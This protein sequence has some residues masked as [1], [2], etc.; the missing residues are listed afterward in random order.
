MKQTCLCEYLR[1]TCNHPD[2]FLHIPASIRRRIYLYAGL[3]T[4]TYIAYP[5]IGSVEGGDDCTIPHEDYVVTYNLTHVCQQIR[6]EVEAIL[7]NRNTCVYFDHNVDDGLDYLSQI[8][9]YTCSMLRNVYVHLYVHPDRNGRYQREPSPLE[10]KRI[11]M[12]QLATTNILSH[13]SP[14]RLRLH[15]ICDTGYSKKTDAVLQPLCNFPGV[16][17]ELELRLHKQE[18]ENKRLTTLARETA[19]QA[20]G[21]N[22][23]APSGIFRFFDL[24]EEIRRNIFAYTNLVAPYRKVHWEPESGFRAEFIFC[25]CD[26]SVCLEADLHDGRRFLSC[27]ADSDITG[28]FCMRYRSS[29]SSRCNHGSSPLSL[30]LVSR[31]MYEEAIAFFYASNRIIIQPDEQSENAIFAGADAEPPSHQ[32]GAAEQTDAATPYDPD[33]AEF[34][35][36]KYMRHD[37]TKLF[38][39]R[40]GSK[41]LRLV[42]NLEIVFPRIGP[43]SSLSDADPAYSEWCMA[44]DYLACLAAHADVPRLTLIV[45]IWTTPAGRVDWPLERTA[46]MVE[47]QAPRLL[48]PLRALSQ[49]ERLFVHLEWP[50]HWSPP[51]LLHDIKTSKVPKKESPGCGIGLHYIPR[52]EEVVAEKEVRLEKMVMDAEYDSYSMGKGDELPSQWVRDQWGM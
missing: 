50:K 47:A 4:G 38:L 2:T 18:H 31:P 30:L 25:E 46:H 7:L 43:D 32:P 33:Q 41:V 14:Q 6:D 45:H 35:G 15:L 1:V 36:T 13:A 29:Y 37:A 9:P 40:L 17:L 48:K 19:L 52:S 23:N 24:P 49:L 28:N 27:G 5:N 10:W 51:K 42:R 12:W 16:L 8:S 3:T 21:Q 34:S 26:G 11:D 39:E 44:V 20:Q 22:P